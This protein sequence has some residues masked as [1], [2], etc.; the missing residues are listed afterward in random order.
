MR[1]AVIRAPHDMGIEELENPRAEPF[2]VIVAVRAVGV[3]AADMSIYRGRLPYGG[4]PQ[5]CGHE[6]T[7]TVAEVGSRVQT[8][9]N[10]RSSRR[11][12]IP[13]LRQALSVSN[14]QNKLLRQTGDHRRAPSW[15]IRGIREGA[16]EKYPH[17]S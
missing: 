6:I 10:G 17:H 3:C 4:Y 12:A 5:V 7:G 1:A 16:G 15:R 2:E 9:Q 8:A 13:G 11:G 14:R